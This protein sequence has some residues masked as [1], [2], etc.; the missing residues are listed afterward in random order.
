MAEGGG[1]YVNTGGALVLN[2]TSI[3]LNAALPNTL[4]NGN[5]RKRKEDRGDVSLVVVSMASR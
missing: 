1:G 2:N 4:E 5:S 3:T